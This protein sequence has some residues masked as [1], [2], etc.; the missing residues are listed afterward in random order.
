[1]LIFP[2][3]HLPRL[4][5]VGVQTSKGVEEIG[6]NVSAWLDKWPDM[7]FEV[8]P[9]RPTET[10]AYPAVCQLIGDVLVWYVCDADTAF[11]GLGAVE[12]VGIA[13]GIRKPSGPCTTEIKKTRQPT[14]VLLGTQ[15]GLPQESM[16]KLDQLATI[17]KTMLHNYVGTTDPDFIKRVDRALSVSVGVQPIHRSKHRWQRHVKRTER[18]VIANGA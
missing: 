14:H 1:M 10:A 7:T 6:F 4:I 11:E 8:W 17:D 2:V 5:P 18:P 3:D 13:E 15:F 12:V 16:L 9:T